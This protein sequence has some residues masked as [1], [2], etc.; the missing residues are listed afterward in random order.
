MNLKAR[1]TCNFNCI[2]E[3]EGLLK[4]TSSHLLYTAKVRALPI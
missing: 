4:V 2:V 1:V 3:I